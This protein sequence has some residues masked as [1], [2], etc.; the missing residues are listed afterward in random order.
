MNVTAK[1][2]RARVSSAIRL[3]RR[4]L[5]VQFMTETAAHVRITKR[6]SALALVSLAAGHSGPVK[7]FDSAARNRC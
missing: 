2:K 7:F 1:M 4:L 5:P 3:T 6:S